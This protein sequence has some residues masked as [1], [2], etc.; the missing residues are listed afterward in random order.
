MTLSVTDDILFTEAVE[1]HSNMIY[2]IAFQYL[3][4]KADAEDVL[5]DVFIK[6][7]EKNPDFEN[8]ENRKA[9]LIRITINLCKDRL[10]SFWRRKTVPLN[11][12]DGQTVDFDTN[13]FNEL[14]LLKP[15]YRIILYLHY[16]EGYSINELSSVMRC[17]PNTVSSRLRQARQQLKLLIEEEQNDEKR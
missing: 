6:L 3:R 12:A 9:W 15:K 11:E 1:K 14:F 8:E 4:N 16:Y 7:L 5:Q 17:N 2:R 13:I 10:R